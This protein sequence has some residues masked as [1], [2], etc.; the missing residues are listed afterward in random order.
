MILPIID[1]N[2]WNTFV[3]RFTYVAPSVLEEMQSVDFRPRLEQTN[4]TNNASSSS[5]NT[6]NRP[7]FSLEFLSLSTINQ[8][9]QTPP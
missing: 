8:H 3:S 5:K 1:I 6:T 2:L 7:L 9:V 4:L